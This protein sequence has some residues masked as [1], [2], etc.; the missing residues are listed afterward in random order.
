LPSNTRYVQFQ[1]SPQQLKPAAISARLYTTRAFFFQL[2]RQAYTVP[3]QQYPG[4][5]LAWQPQEVLKLPDDVR[6]ALQPNPR[7]IADDAW[8]KLIWAAC[9]LS[10][11]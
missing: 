4:V 10:T 8:F 2:Q 1:T 3:G 5:Q 6:A 9:T 11:V 7:D